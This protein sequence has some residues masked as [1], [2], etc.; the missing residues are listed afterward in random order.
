MIASP[1]RAA[2]PRFDRCAVAPETW[3][4]HAVSHVHP[5]ATSTDSLAASDGG[6]HGFPGPLSGDRSAIAFPRSRPL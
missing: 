3:P 4:L 1:H 6:G 5:P 2:D